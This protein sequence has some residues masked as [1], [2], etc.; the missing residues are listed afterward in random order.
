MTSLDREGDHVSSRGV[1]TV[2][3]IASDT[4]QP[5]LSS[6]ATLTLTL[7]DINDCSPEII[8]SPKDLHVLEESEPSMIGILTATDRD[9]WSLGH[10]PPFNFSLAKINKPPI[11]QLLT[12]KNFP[13]E[14][15][16]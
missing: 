9:V 1:T 8:V 10:G 6:T 15:I 13:G 11:L 3:V 14:Y 4:G 12:L 5:P 7:T 2:K 16:Y